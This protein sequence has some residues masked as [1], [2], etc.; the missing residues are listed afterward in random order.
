ME[1]ASNL[2]DLNRRLHN[3]NQF[4]AEI[5]IIETAVERS[6]Q[7]VVQTVLF[8]IANYYSR[9]L[10]LFDELLF[11]PIKVVFV[12]N[13][14]QTIIAMTNSIVR[15]RN[16]KRFP[17]STPAIGSI[18]QK[19]AISIWIAGKTMFISASLANMP[20]LHP[21]GPILEMTIVFLFH[22]IIS[23][24]KPTKNMETT[25]GIAVTSV[26]HRPQP[27]PSA[28]TEDESNNNENSQ[29]SKFTKFFEPYLSLRANGGILSMLM[30]EILSFSIYLGISKLVRANRT[31]INYEKYIEQKSS[32]N[33]NQQYRKNLGDG[34]L[35][36]FFLPWFNIIFVNVEI[37]HIA[38]AIA[39]LFGLYCIYLL[40]IFA[41]YKIGHPKSLIINNWKE[42]EDKKTGIEISNQ[43]WE[44]LELNHSEND[45]NAQR[46]GDNLEERS[47]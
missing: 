40:L 11:V 18:F 28:R 24:F 6:P 5:D 38:C 14:F 33:L 43:L 32:S 34:G 22:L 13:W 46:P 10:V 17:M 21:I 1:I 7:L 41:Y 30:L 3:L 12:V 42:K 23:R 15:Y 4:H 19:L 31:P 35:K 44:H 2:E 26:F 47:S 39:V 8:I 37:V 20:F 27:R 9:V 45:V 25:F 16:V 29:K 36:E